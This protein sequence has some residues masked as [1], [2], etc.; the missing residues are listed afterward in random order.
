MSLT[1]DLPD[2]DPENVA[3]SATDAATDAVEGDAH[4]LGLV[5]D[6]ASESPTFI[7][8]SGGGSF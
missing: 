2:V 8:N 5:G 3:Q 4:P 6:A 1:P 7:E